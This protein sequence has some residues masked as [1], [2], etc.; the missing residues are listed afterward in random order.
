MWQSPDVIEWEQAERELAVLQDGVGG[1]L[2]FGGLAMGRESG[3]RFAGERD[4]ALA[5]RSQA[6]A[7]LIVFG[8]RG[9]AR[10]VAVE[11]VLS[12][13]LGDQALLLGE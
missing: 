5:D 9:S 11:R 13:L 7:A 10:I 1:E 8:T 12:V 6:A 2:S 4:E 3:V